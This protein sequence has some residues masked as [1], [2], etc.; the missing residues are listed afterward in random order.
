MKV[1]P[2]QHIL[3]LKR[4]YELRLTLRVN[5][6]YY[7][8]RL[9]RVQMW[10]FWLSILIALTVSG[11][12]IGTILHMNDTP[13]WLHSTFTGTMIIATIASIVRPIYA[14]AKRVER[15]T[16]QWRA[17]ESNFNAIDKLLINIQTKGNV[18]D[19]HIRR[20]DSIFDRYVATESND[21]CLTSRYAM[22]KAQAFAMQESPNDKLWWPPP[23]L[24]HD[25]PPPEKK[26]RKNGQI[27]NLVPAPSD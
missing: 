14:P 2:A 11:S 7:E 1:W 17:Y 4:I 15:F 10:S 3:L 18:Q 5:A 27:L 13:P 6:I 23:E 25:E 20:F 19:Q 21:D 9:R 22:K 24:S 16:R 26:R 8:R 12:G